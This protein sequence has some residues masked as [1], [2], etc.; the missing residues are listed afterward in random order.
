MSYFKPYIDT[1]GY[2]YPTYNEIL[3]ALIDDMQTIYGTGIYLGNDSQ[4][5]ELLSKFAE[6]IYDTYQV[7]EVIYNSHSPATAIGTGLDNIVAVSGITRKQATRST[8]MVTLTGAAGSIIENGS[9]ADESGV[10]WDL[11]E[12]VEIGS[13]GSVTVEAVCREYGVISAAAGTVTRIMTPALG[14][15]SV[16]NLLD[17]YT[18]TVVETDS[19]LRARQA[20]SVALPSRSVL[21][22]LIAALQL[23]TD[24]GRV[25]VYENDTNSTDANGIPAHSICAVVEGGADAD[26]AETIFMRKGL[27]CGTYGTTTV[28][29]QDGTGTS[30][31]IKFEKLGYVDVDIQITMTKRAGWSD[32]IPDK[33]RTAIVDYLDT[34]AIGT[35]LTT[36]IIWMVA[37]TV[38]E[39]IRVPQFSITLVKAAVHGE[40]L[41]V[42][43]VVIGF[44]E[45]ARGRATNIEIIATS[46]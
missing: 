27:G 42:G 2:H 45:T 25:E 21:D 16:T 31:N 15:T 43:D 7:C 44:N 23:I 18:G 11:P 14:W 9:V 19:E 22:S 39:D 28:V 33:I 20:R 32:T 35:D 6:K 30:H 46:S 38:N 41:G 13:G 26:V 1:S 5:Y 8:V 12:V 4:D 36:S 40:T 29:V 37:Q 10:M 17:A 34:F 3:G 24:I